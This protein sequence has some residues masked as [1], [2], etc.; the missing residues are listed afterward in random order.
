MRLRPPLPYG[1]VGQLLA[2]LPEP[3]PEPLSAVATE[4]GPSSDPLTVGAG[5]VELLGVL[6]DKGP[7]VVVIDDAHWADMPSL[8]AVAFA[9][10]RLRVDRVLGLISAR[11]EALARWSGPSAPCD[12]RPI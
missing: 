7:V 10:R 6:Q 3:L 11:D 9:L 1:V 5:L 2:G 8:H 12:W 4:T